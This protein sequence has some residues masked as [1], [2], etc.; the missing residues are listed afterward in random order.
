VTNNNRTKRVK[1]NNF[2]PVFVRYFL[3]FHIRLYLFVALQK[4]EKPGHVQAFYYYDFPHRTEELPEPENEPL[5]LRFFT[6]IFRIS[7]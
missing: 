4:K 7:E 2:L 5:S 3:I 6:F 1:D